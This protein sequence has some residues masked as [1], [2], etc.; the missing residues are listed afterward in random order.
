MKFW[1]FGKI[2]KNQRHKSGHTI[3]ITTVFFPRE[4]YHYTIQRVNCVLGYLKIKPL[5]FWLRSLSAR[6]MVPS[7]EIARRKVDMFSWNQSQQGVVI[8]PCCTPLF[9]RCV[10]SLFGSSYFPSSSIDGIVYQCRKVYLV[11][12]FRLPLYVHRCPLRT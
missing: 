3:F 6:F 11:P 1:L 10:Y 4:V 7:N 12:K 8:G 2:P 9:W 5:K